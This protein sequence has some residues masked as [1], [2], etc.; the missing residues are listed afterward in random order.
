[1]GALVIHESHS[2]AATAAIVIVAIFV[3]VWLLDSGVDR[4][5]RKWGWAANFFGV[6]PGS[7]VKVHGWW[8]SA[9]RD[10]KGKLLGGS[11][12]MIRPGL[13][14]VELSGI[15]KDL[16]TSVDQWTWWSGEGTPYGS[17]SI[18][19][20]YTGV[21]AG[22]DDYGYGMYSF[23]KGGPP[24]RIRGSFYGR[25]LPKAERYRTA[26]G[27]RAPDD[28]VDREFRKNPDVRKKAL[29]RYLEQQPE[30]P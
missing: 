6:K 14:L 19:Y 1:M 7:R 24:Q 10:Q 11:V 4:C 21:E 2:L 17:E 5:V 13:E 20:G 26:H 3:T 16:T 23:P 25:N 8:Y 9:I 22:E 15:Y 28:I 12:F 30:H 27:E 29:E 18:V